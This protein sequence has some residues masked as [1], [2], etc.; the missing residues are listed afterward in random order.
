MS[1]V[2]RIV[3]SAAVLA[4]TALA[5]T[6]D[7]TSFPG[8]G[9][10][11]WINSDTNLFYRVEWA[12]SLT[13]PDA[14]HSNY[15]ALIDIRS[16]ASIVTS[17]VP[18]FY[19]VC[20]SSN[21]VVFAAPVPKTG[22]TTVYQSGD[23]GDYERG[24]ALPKPRFTIGASGD[25][26]NCVT[27][28]LTGLVW[29]RNA[30]LAGAKTWTAAITYCEGLTYGGAN[31]WRLPN[32]K[33]LQSLQC[34]GWLTPVLGNTDGTKAWAQG[35]PFWNV[36]LTQDYWSSTI[37]PNYTPYAWKT[38]FFNGDVNADSRTSYATFVWPVRGGL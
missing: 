10:L 15:A 27:D 3:M 12:P 4:G 22:Q 33:E 11:T 14:W 23:D 32:L 21:R 28:N 5:Q 38:S 19:R 31:D 7:I 8:N 35:D 1:K 34:F 24:L 25:T 29:A 2:Y 18:M 36:Q 20:G 13:V 16:S 17:T 6:P 37:T 9:Q 26:T 30:N